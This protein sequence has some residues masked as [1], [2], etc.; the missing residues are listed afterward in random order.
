MV[1]IL[2]RIG[3]AAVPCE[4]YAALTDRGRM[5]SWWTRE[6][7]GEPDVGSMIHF[8]F[9]ERGFFDMKLIELDPDNSVVWE[10][11]NGPSEWIGTKILWDLSPY[12][13]DTTV[14]F[15]Q[16]G[17]RARVYFMHRWRT[18]WTT[19]L[20]SLKSLLETRAVHTRRTC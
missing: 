2:H 4:V 3:I 12:G 6:I 20:L 13:T 1:D 19:F 10:V 11:V 8:N 7:N 16:K 9:G 18:K 5:A 17:W 15:K 14:R